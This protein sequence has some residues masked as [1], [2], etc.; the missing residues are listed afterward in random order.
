M[1]LDL[2]IL[3]FLHWPVGFFGDEMGE[4][5]AMTEAAIKRQQGSQSE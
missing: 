5:L 4:L 1:G 2:S 3:A